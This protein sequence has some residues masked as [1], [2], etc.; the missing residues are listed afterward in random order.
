MES[1]YF[2]KPDK[3]TL[4]PNGKVIKAEA[5]NDVVAAEDIVAQARATADKILAHAK[6]EYMEEKERGYQ[7]GLMQAKAEMSG[8][9]TETVSQTAQYFDNL[10]DKMVKLVM[11]TLTTILGNMDS[12]E[13]VQKIVGKALGSVRNE[14]QITIRVHPSYAKSVKKHIDRYTAAFPKVN[15]FEVIAEPRMQLAD[16]ILESEAGYVDGSLEVQLKAIKKAFERTLR[17]KPGKISV[18]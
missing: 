9:I 1:F 3:P 8:K 2:V 16:C 18:K 14:K 10:E 6:K 4:R 11:R 7:E 17:Q 5:L 13:I 15:F 12:D